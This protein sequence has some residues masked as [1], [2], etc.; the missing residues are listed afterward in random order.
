MQWPEGDDS[1]L[2]IVGQQ[3]GPPAV[4]CIPTGPVTAQ[5]KTRAKPSQTPRSTHRPRHEDR[6]DADE[7]AQRDQ[8]HRKVLPHLSKSSI[9][10]I[11]EALIDSEMAL[12]VGYCDDIGTSPVA[13]RRDVYQREGG[14]L[15]RTHAARAFRIPAGRRDAIDAAA[16]FVR[17]IGSNSAR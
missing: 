14:L 15:D 16:I 3:A 7:A 11:L 12:D 2:S 4:A 10:A 17:S 13:I 1:G 6:H 9:S 5:N 8:R